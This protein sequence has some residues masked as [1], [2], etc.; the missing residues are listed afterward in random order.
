MRYGTPGAQRAE[1]LQI[2]RYLDIKP[3]R[4]FD[5]GNHESKPEWRPSESKNKPIRKRYDEST[6]KLNDW[7]RLER[8]IYLGTESSY[9]PHDKHPHRKN[10]ECI[11]RLISAGKGVE[12]VQHLSDISQR[13]R[14]LRQNYLIFALAI[15]ARSNDKETKKEAYEELCAIC[16]IPT[17]FFLF[18]NYCQQESLLSGS[19]GWG[20]AHRRAMIKWYEEKAKHPVSLARLL[21]KYKSRRM[22]TTDRRGETWSHTKILKKAHPK[23]EDDFMTV[24]KQYLFNGFEEA[25]NLAS[26]TEMNSESIAKISDL[27]RRYRESQTMHL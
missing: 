21:T 20:R 15:C 10:A 24:V 22:H 1:R 27:H 11:D 8:F 7:G 5:I 18:V 25:Q 19:K 9:N 13:G 17:H 23:F 2:I 16:R 6:H 14:T 26:S 12:V 3:K 4:Y